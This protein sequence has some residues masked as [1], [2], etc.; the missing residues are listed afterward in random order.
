MNAGQ[1]GDVWLATVQY[2]AGSAILARTWCDAKASLD[3]LFATSAATETERRSLERRCLKAFL[4]ARRECL[5]TI[6]KLAAPYLA[7]AENAQDSRDVAAEVDAAIKAEVQ[8]VAERHARRRPSTN[9][10]LPEPAEPRSH[11]SCAK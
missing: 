6:D 4:A 8:R 11:T 1:A 9:T 10:P 7:A 5:A 3:S 2:T